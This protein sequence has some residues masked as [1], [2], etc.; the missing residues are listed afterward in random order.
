M[1]LRPNNP[2]HYGLIEDLGDNQLSLDRTV[3][4][5]NNNSLDKLY[6]VS[7]GDELSA[8]S[9]KFYKDSKYWW[10]IADR[11]KL[12]NPFILEVGKLLIIPNL[13]VALTYI[14]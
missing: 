1:K 10:I 9:Y 11:N 12:E 13:E 7:E 6:T 5:I 8:L 2:Y 4:E 14:P 3:L